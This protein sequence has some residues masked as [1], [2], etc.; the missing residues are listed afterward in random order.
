LKREEDRLTDR[1]NSFVCSFAR[2]EIRVATETK[3]KKNAKKGSGK[4][5][6]TDM[7]TLS[8]SLADIV[9]GAG[10]VKRTKTPT[11]KR[12]TALVSNE[13]TRMQ[14]VL[15][16]PQY[17][18]NPIAA[19]SNHILTGLA[20]DAEARGN[21]PG[22]NKPKRKK[23]LTPQQERELSGAHVVGPQE[24]K[25]KTGDARAVRSHK[26]GGTKRGKLFRA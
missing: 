22:A 16:H 9:G 7:K 2:A 17:K 14:A 20:A 6:V 15:S 8:L 11:A 12:R 3:M 4:M 10:S 18:A 24:T 25:P 19:I 23:K 26:H 1:R 13:T 21:K 5:S